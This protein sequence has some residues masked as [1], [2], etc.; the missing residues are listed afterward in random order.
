MIKNPIFIMGNCIK[1]FA[2]L[3]YEEYIF[4]EYKVKKQRKYMKNNNKRTYLRN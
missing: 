3:I 4:Y 1:V 2:E